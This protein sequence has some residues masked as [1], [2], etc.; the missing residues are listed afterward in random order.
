MANFRMAI[1]SPKFQGDDESII[2]SLTTTP[3]A[4]GPTTAVVAVED[5]SNVNLDVTS[6]V[7][8]VNAPTVVGDVISL[9]A[10]KLL[11]VGHTYR[12]EIRFAAGGNTFE[13]WFVVN[14]EQ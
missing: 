2:Y 6:S 10:L 1:E 4:S 5:M 3:W 11:T 9:S 8:P 12:V 7:M 13:A 14:C